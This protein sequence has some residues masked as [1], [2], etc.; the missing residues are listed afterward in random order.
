MQPAGDEKERKRFQ[1]AL[2]EVGEN[3][4]RDPVEVEGADVG[5]VERSGEGEEEIVRKSLDEPNADTPR[6]VV[7]DLD[8]T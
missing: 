1:G 5:R 8:L 4:P 2:E 3:L 7:Q 6:R